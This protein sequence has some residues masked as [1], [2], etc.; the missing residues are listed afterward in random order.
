MQGRALKFLISN[1]QTLPFFHSPR[2]SQGT[3]LRENFTIYLQKKIEQSNV[4]EISASRVV[5]LYNSDGFD[6]IIISD[7]TTS[8]V[9]LTIHTIFCLDIFS[10]FYSL[11][12]WF[13][14]HPRVQT[15]NY[16]NFQEERKFIVHLFVR[17]CTSN[18]YWI[19]KSISFLHQNKAVYFHQERIII[20]KVFW[21][22]QFQV[23]LLKSLREDHRVLGC[24]EKC[25]NKTIFLYAT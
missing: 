6:Q 12:S 17:S 2:R 15:A 3:S 23:Q 4:N 20:K 18:F 9:F 11:L 24:N 1:F 21:L 14:K 7:V 25:C 19:A 5:E 16:V 22:F 8:Q 10:T 13:C